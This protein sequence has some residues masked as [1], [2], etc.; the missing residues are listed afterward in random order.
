V[1]FHSYVA[2]YQRVVGFEH[3]HNPLSIHLP[4]WKEIVDGSKVETLFSQTGGFISD[5][6]WTKTADGRR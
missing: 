5:H 6:Q 1:I 3:P 2:V 4:V